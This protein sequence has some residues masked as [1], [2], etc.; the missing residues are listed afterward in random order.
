MRGI[1]FLFLPSWTA[2]TCPPKVPILAKAALQCLQIW[3]LAPVWTLRWSL[4]LHKSFVPYPHV[5]Q[6]YVLALS[7]VWA[8]IIC[9]FKKA[10][11]RK[12]FPHF[13]HVCGEW[14][15]LTCPSIRSGCL[16][17]T[18]H[19]SCV[20][21][22][23]CVPCTRFMC[24]S[25]YAFEDTVFPHCEQIFFSLIWGSFLLSQVLDRCVRHWASDRK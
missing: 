18:S 25:K 24:P 12:V 23:E 17:I 11:L 20:Q 9:R 5:S 1:H 10:L 15:N 13:S 21:G 14:Y 16:R 8:L 22:M 2:L 6:I 4:Y 3:G 19:P 7:A